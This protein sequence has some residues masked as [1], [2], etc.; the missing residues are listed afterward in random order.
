MIMHR[1]RQ[2][3]LKPMLQVCRRTPP[4]RGRYRS[5]AAG[6]RS[7]SA[8]RG[9]PSPSTP[10]A[11]PHWLRFTVNSQILYCSKKVRLTCNYMRDPFNSRTVYEAFGAQVGAHLAMTSFLGWACPRALVAGVNLTMRAETT[12]VLSKAGMLAQVAPYCLI[13]I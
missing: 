3:N 8:S 5:C 1:Q 6:S 4:P 11:P 7:P 12:A 10:P 9:P 2:L 13:N